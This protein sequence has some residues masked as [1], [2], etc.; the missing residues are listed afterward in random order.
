MQIAPTVVK[1]TNE[2]HK[3]DL[4]TMNLSLARRSC[5]SVF[6]LRIPTQQVAA[7]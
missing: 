1:R 2:S 4:A 3:A 6:S 7:R 5:V